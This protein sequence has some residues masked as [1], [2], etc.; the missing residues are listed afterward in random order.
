L[1]LPT[2]NNK[3]ANNTTS[4]KEH[5]TAKNK[6]GELP[7]EV[8]LPERLRVALMKLTKEE[9]M[10][11][12]RWRGTGQG[13]M[14]TTAERLPH[15]NRAPAAA[16]SNNSCAR[17]VGVTHRTSDKAT[18]AFS[19]DKQAHTQQQKSKSTAQKQGNRVTTSRKRRKGCT[20]IETLKQG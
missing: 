11:S 15:E 18:P 17:P 9:L 6:A 10:F 12:T 3:I 1:T 20:K 13:D 8:L 7:E 5:R 4:G 16:A 2:L 14:I 19:R